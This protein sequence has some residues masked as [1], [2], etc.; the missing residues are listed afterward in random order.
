MNTAYDRKNARRW[1]L[2]E[3][4]NICYFLSSEDIKEVDYLFQV[5]GVHG[6]VVIPRSMHIQS[7]KMKHIPYEVD[8]QERIDCEIEIQHWFYERAN[9]YRQEL[10][11][12]KEEVWRKRA[13]RLA[14]ERLGFFALAVKVI[15]EECILEV[16]AVK[17][18]EV[19]C[20]T[21]QEWDNKF[22]NERKLIEAFLTRSEFEGEMVRKN[23]ERASRIFDKYYTVVTRIQRTKFCT[24][25]YKVFEKYL[26]SENITFENWVYDVALAR[27]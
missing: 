22:S 26:R 10:K 24:V 1:Q 19:Y 12:R 11:R 20:R 8:P 2:S 17:C 14:D 21:Y 23:Y 3:Q 15:T 16:A 4:N 6:E 5:R 18:L 9:A 13:S 27:K 7:G 25:N